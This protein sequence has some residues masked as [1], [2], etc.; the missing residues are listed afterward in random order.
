MTFSI[1]RHLRR[2]PHPFAS[3]L[4]THVHSVD[5]AYQM[6]LELLTAEVN[7]N[8]EGTLI[9]SLDRRRQIIGYSTLPVFFMQHGV[10]LLLFLFLKHVT[11][12]RSHFSSIKILPYLSKTLEAVA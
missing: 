3:K 6:P 7:S 11:S 5:V 4:S 1:L 10:V 8:L 12:L 2:D 9:E